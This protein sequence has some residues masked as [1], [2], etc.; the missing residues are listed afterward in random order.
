[1]TLE[2]KVGGIS[3]ARDRVLLLPEL[4]EAIVRQLSARDIL[5]NAQRISHLFKAAISKSAVIQKVLFFQ[6]DLARSTSEFKF[7]PLLRQAFSLWFPS[8]DVD[9]SQPPFGGF[10]VP[11]AFLNLD[12]NRDGATREAYARKEASWRKMLPAQPP[13]RVLKVV[14]TT[15]GELGC[16]K[17]RGE[18]AFEN[19]LRMGSLY[20]LTHRAMVEPICVFWMDWNI[21]LPAGTQEH[22]DWSGLPGGTSENDTPPQT[23]GK[24]ASED[25]SD[26]VTLNLI[27][28]E[29][30]SLDMDSS[31]GPEFKSHGYEEIEVRFTERTFKE[32]E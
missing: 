31:L 28:T 14:H 10:H 5:V 13:V 15:S 21:F 16:L 22:L 27:L 20:D 7:N 6:P 12:W 8:V 24:A 3:T 26:K 30:C 2:G 25:P 18:V 29:Q 32:Y 23:L 17:R 9:I 4:V 1:M 19:G 11:E